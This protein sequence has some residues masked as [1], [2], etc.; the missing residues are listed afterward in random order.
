MPLNEYA[1]FPKQEYRGMSQIKCVYKHIATDPHLDNEQRTEC[2][3]EIV[4][5]NDSC[6]LTRNYGW[7]QIDSVINQKNRNRVKFMEALQLSNTYKPG[8]TGGIYK[9]GNIVKEFGSMFGT[10]YSYTEHLP[11]INWQLYDIRKTVCGHKCQKALA[12]YRGRDWEAWYAED[13]PFS[14]GP[15]KFNGLPGLILELSSS[16]GEHRYVAQ[17]VES[18]AEHIL[19]DTIREVFTTRET[20]FKTLM[21]YRTNSSGYFKKLT[22]STIQFHRMFFNP[23]EKDFKFLK[24]NP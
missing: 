15:Y 21:N 24:Q 11:N 10:H 9:A 22:S 20:Y 2:T 1:K 3:M 19:V 13:L 8:K 12:N 7:Y 14:N 4:L 5:L 6:S 16:D 18:S 23:V 17:L